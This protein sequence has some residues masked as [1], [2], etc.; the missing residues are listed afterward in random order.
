V[1]IIGKTSLTAS[2]K[3]HLSVA[4]KLPCMLKWGHCEN[5]HE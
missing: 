2:E 5:L 3:H 4:V 1:N